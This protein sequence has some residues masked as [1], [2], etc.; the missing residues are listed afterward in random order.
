MKISDNVLNILE[1]SKV[2]HQG[3]HTSLV[4]TQQLDRKDYVAVNKVLECLGGQWNKKA[5]AHIFEGNVTDAIDQAMIAGEVVDAKK[6]FQ[7]FKTPLKLA[8]DMVE[9]AKIISDKLRVLEPSAGDGSIA[10]QIKFLTGVVPDCVELWEKNRKILTEKGL[11]LVGQDFLQFKPMKLYDR[12]VANPPFTRQQDV[13]HVM[14]MWECLKPG[15]KIVAL[16]SPSWTFRENMKSR[17]FRTFLANQAR[18]MSDVPAGT[19]KESG[20]EIRTILLEL[21]KTI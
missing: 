20:T 21:T 5:K 4:I 11:P 8:A 14:H 1:S 10:E 9:R 7:F 13:D 15:G 18:S 2:E 3:T 16:M 6:E 19:F 12:I 17:E